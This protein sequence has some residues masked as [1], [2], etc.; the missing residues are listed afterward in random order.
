MQY[1]YQYTLYIDT[2]AE[3]S[4][5]TYGPNSYKHVF[6]SIVQP[7]QILSQPYNRVQQ[8]LWSVPV[9]MAIQLHEIKILLKWVELSM[10]ICSLV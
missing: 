1:P 10:L 8:N 5:I 7:H 3:Q 9:H 6:K 2:F 4:L